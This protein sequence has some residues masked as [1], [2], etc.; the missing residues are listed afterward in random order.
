MLRQ[1]ILVGL[2]VGAAVSLPVLYESNAR[3]PQAAFWADG[4]EQPATV[5]MTQSVA[6]ESSPAPVVSS[7]GRKVEIPSDSRGYYLGHFKVNGRQ[8]EALIDTGATAVAFNLSTARRLGLQVQA[9]DMTQTVNTANGKTKATSVMISRLE[10]GRVSVE[11]VQA[12]VLE[13]RALST[14]LIGMSFLNRLKKFQVDEGRLLLV[15]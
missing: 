8:V 12:I 6:M 9:A 1:M 5:E 4:A 11:N 10:I 7:S 14:N 3:F 13:D 2:F 15:Q